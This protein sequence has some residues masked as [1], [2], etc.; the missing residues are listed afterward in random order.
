[1][2]TQTGS[3]VVFGN[4][5]VAATPFTGKIIV[6]GSDFSPTSE[7][8]QIK[9][10]SGDLVTRIFTNPG[11][12]ATIECIATGTDVADARTN[13]SAL[14]SLYQTIVNITASTDAPHLVGSNWFVVDVKI[15]ASNEDVSKVTLSL[16]Q[17]AGITA[18]AA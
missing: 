16:E 12:K 3:K 14:A 9:G 10:A 11:K 2:A 1:M 17:H 5:G 7:E 18:S 6:Q 13:Q 8:K 15:A 4:S